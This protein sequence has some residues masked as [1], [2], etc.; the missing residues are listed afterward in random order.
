M[1]ETPNGLLITP[2]P[3]LPS[4][5]KKV[6]VVETIIENDLVYPLIRGRDV[7]KFVDRDY[8]WIIIPHDQKMEK[9]IPETSLS[10][11]TQKPI[12]FL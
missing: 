11:N 5:K 1:D 8:G 2:N 10:Q 6:E 4:Q 9:P 3:I 12:V 7:K